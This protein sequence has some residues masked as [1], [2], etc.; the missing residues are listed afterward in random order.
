MLYN[1]LSTVCQNRFSLIA[2]SQINQKDAAVLQTIDVLHVNGKYYDI[3]KLDPSADAHGWSYAE[4]NVYSEIPIDPDVLLKNCPEMMGLY[5]AMTETDQAWR[6]EGVCWSVWDE[7]RRCTTCLERWCWDATFGTSSGE[8][9]FVRVVTTDAEG[10]TVVVGNALLRRQTEACL[11]LFWR[12]H[13]SLAFGRALSMH[14]TSMSDGDP[15]LAKIAREAEILQQRGKHGTAV[16]ICAFH[17]LFKTYREEYGR[18]HGRFDGG[19]GD[20]L[21]AM[22]RVM[23]QTS[24]TQ[25][26]SKVRCK[27]LVLTYTVRR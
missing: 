6:C 2:K 18:T 16:T 15:K 20:T 12:I 22:L 26:E 5:P 11:R 13:L 9:P 8:H 3:T 14:S 27:I 21:M 19:I 10:N 24:E 4:H 23:L 7:V 1:L 17:A 25:E